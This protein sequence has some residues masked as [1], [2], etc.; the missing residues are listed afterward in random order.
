MGGGYNCRAKHLLSFKKV[1]H[2]AM[3]MK[4]EIIYASQKWTIKGSKTKKSRGSYRQK[5]TKE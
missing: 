4:T 5:W 2:E 3:N 1:Q